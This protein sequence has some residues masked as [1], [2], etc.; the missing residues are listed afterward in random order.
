MPFAES[1]EARIHWDESGQGEPLLLVMGFGLSG[2]AWAPLLPLLGGYRVIWYDNRGTGESTGPMEDLRIEAFAEDAAAVLRSAGV[3]R[4]H[5]HGESMGGMI[6]QQLTLAHPEMVHTLSLGCTTPAPVRFFP[7][8]PQAVMDLFMSVSMFSSDPDRAIDLVMPAV[9]SPEYLRDNP[10]VRDMYRDLASAG[11][12]RPD[13]VEAT[14]RAMGDLATGQA[15]DVADR[16]G[17]ISAPTLV[18]HGAADRIIPVAAGRYI[19][20]HVPGAEY[21]E[22]PGAGHI[23]LM[24]QP[25][26][27]LPRLLRFWK[28]HPMPG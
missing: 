12:P 20:E 18:Q 6:A 10:T 13:A 24:E 26:E 25:M 2:Q 16:L 11:A 1:G 14:M 17:E 27:A 15:F 5:V 4:A 8:D 23:Y 21:Q 9:F 7:D 22:L 28:S 3:T 19:A